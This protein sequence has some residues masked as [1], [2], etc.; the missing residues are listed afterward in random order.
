MTIGGETLDKSRRSRG[1]QRMPDASLTDEALLDVMPDVSPRRPRIP[2][3]GVASASTR[4]DAPEDVSAL[5]EELAALRHEH[6]KLRQAIFEAAQVQRRLCAPRELTWGKFE[7]AGEIFPVRHLSGDFFKVFELGS[8]LGIVVGDIAGKGLSAGIWMIHLTSIV[9]RCA[10]VHADPAAAIAEVNRELC[11]GQGEPPLTA[12]F[13]ARL[14]PE[15]GEIVYC[16]AGLPG[17]L[18]LRRN[19][20][21]ASLNEGGP[22]LGAV[23]EGKFNSGSVTLDPGDTLIA[24]SDGVTECRN[25]RDE[26][27]DTKGLSAAAKAACGA[28][29][30][31]ALFSTLGAVLDF[32]DGCS[33]NDD[34]TLLVVRRREE[35][36]GTQARSGSTDSSTMR[37]G[38][39]TAMHA[40]GA[41]R[42]SLVS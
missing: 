7:I 24:Y 39:T 37:F 36:A 15:R 33:P 20:V 19:K 25:S 13:F 10:R 22:I 17:P 11:E 5:Q 14:D 41:A 8:A 3:I 21:V 42:E 2:A 18:V 29:A 16:N 32:A 40:G 34:L 1:D 9:Q 26:E 23:R 12:L 31:Q 30:S 38:R 27:F 28:G 6:A 35:I 4:E